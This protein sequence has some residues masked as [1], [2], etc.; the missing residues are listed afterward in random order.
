MDSLLVRTSHTDGSA[1]GL[2]FQIWPTSLTAACAAGQMTSWHIR[3]AS[4]CCQ[5]HT[6]DA[7]L[8]FIRAVP[9]SRCSQ[10]PH[11]LNAQLIGQGNSPSM[12]LAPLS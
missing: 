3:R 2:S 10:L 4:Q 12:A 8:E 1:F 7:M 5:P 11:P 6:Q 9:G